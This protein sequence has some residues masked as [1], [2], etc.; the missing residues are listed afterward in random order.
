MIKQLLL[1]SITA[2]ILLALPNI[3]KLKEGESVDG[4][5]KFKEKLYY[6]VPVSANTALKVKLTNLTADS[7]IYVST[8]KLPTIR[9]NDCYSSNGSTKDDECTVTIS[10][11]PSI[12]TKEVRILVYGFRSSDFTLETISQ[13]AQ[14]PEKLPLYQGVEKHINFNASKDFEFKGKRGMTYRVTLN[15]LSADADLRVKTGKR[16]NKHTF[17][18]KSTKGGKN[19]DR[20]TIKLTNDATIYMNVFGFRDAD[21][22]IMIE[23]QLKNA[24]ITI[25]KLKEMIANGE[26]V[27]K[28]NTSKI[29]DM[30]YMFSNEK[31]FNQDISNWDVSNVT[32]MKSMFY[33]AYKF[34][35]PI[36][37]W[38]VSKVTNMADMFHDAREFNQPIGNWNVSKVTTMKSMFAANASTVFNQPIGN[39]NVSN[40]KDMSM[41][42][43]SSN[44]FNQP[45][46]DWDVSNVR[47]MTQ[48][49]YGTLNFNQPIDK[50][51]VSSVT[52]MKALFGKADRFNQSIEGWDVSNVTDME[53]MFY[54][55]NLR[56]NDLSKW[57]VK[58]VQNHQDF[59]TASGRNNIEPKWNN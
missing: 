50:W 2:Q 5:V 19:E 12:R 11:N 42:F 25:E 4:S 9:S 59:F 34:N 8:D 33:N 20:C 37:K 52:S 46:E 15:K 7:D 1:L 6:S 26:D 55:S 28:V 32:N 38:D 47:D 31:E 40:V 45:I 35:Q 43:D 14:Y 57:N 49:F 41:M 13:K 51:D 29:T 56:N 30:S 39:W 18:C 53:A 10:N 21:Y 24:P 27:T 44:E 48:M 17:D 3:H 16:A 54:S 58:K 36:G 23:A 22:Q